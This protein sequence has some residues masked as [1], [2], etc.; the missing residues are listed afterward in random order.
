MSGTGTGQDVVARTVV[1][2]Q[3]RAAAEAGAADVG[4]V[5]G[6]REAAEVERDH[7]TAPLSVTP[8]K[9]VAEEVPLRASRRVRPWVRTASPVPA[10]EPTVSAKVTVSWVPVPLRLRRAPSPR[11]P[12][13]RLTV[14]A[15]LVPTL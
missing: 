11:T 5:S 12:A 13:A 4:E 2:V 10:R 1:E 14:R 9:A 8:V 15:E 6:D 3:G 7:A